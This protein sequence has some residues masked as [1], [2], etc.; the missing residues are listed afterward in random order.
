MVIINIVSYQLTEN[1]VLT[2]SVPHLEGVRTHASNFI[3]ERNA[4][5]HVH[6]DY[7]FGGLIAGA[8]EID[9]GHCGE[10]HILEPGGILLTEADEVYAGRAL[11]KP[12]WR[13]FS[14]SISKEKLGSVLDS[15]NPERQIKLP[16]FTQGAIRND[17]IRQRF[18]KLHNSLT[19]EITALEQETLLLDWVISVK[20][21][22]AEQA[23]DFHNRRVYSESR[24]IRLVREFIRE[25]VADNI[26][27]ENLAEIAR[28]SPFHLN[29]SFSAQVGLPPHEFQNQLRIEKAAQLIAQ[30]KPL[31][32][33]ALETGFSDQS[34]FNRFF[35]RYTG[36]TPKNF[37]AR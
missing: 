9:C 17:Q 1:W 25:N 34:H 24:A 8:M 2:Q 23:N 32:E 26:R 3:S 36:V 14:I 21:I 10:K 30:K 13:F 19:G 35:K 16:H 11:G 12:P 27:L 5:R 37:F 33:I 6:H 22:Y 4:P 15:I 18:L 28:L 31:A 20:E 29:R 7:V